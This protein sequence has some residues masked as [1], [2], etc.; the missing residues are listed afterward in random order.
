VYP[1]RTY[2]PFSLPQTNHILIYCLLTTRSGLGFYLEQPRTDPILIY[3]PHPTQH[4]TSLNIL[5]LS[6]SLLVH[7]YICY[8]DTEIPFIRCV[9][10]VGQNHWSLLPIR[11]RRFI[12]FRNQ[13]SG[14]LTPSEIADRQSN[15]SRGKSSIDGQPSRYLLTDGPLPIKIW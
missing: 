5:F 13:V 10:I 3:V 2:E 1:C 8:G 12:H 14:G 7:I 15:K 11:S 9:W 4:K 6:H